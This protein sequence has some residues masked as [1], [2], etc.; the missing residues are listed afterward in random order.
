[1]N[2]P[3]TEKTCNL[4]NPCL[5]KDQKDCSIIHP[6]HIPESEHDQLVRLREQVKIYREMLETW[7][8]DATHSLRTEP[9]QSERRNSVLFERASDWSFAKR[10]FDEVFR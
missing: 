2:L 1:M 7:S 9:D 5:H 8:K 4:C 3:E 10:K 6:K